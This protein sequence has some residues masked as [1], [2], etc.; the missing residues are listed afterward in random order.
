MVACESLWLD[1]NQ[2]TVLPAAVF[3]GL[4]NLRGLYLNNNELT[5]L[6]AEAF[7]CLTNLEELS[8]FNNQLTALPGG[9]FNCLTDLGILHQAEK[10]PI[11]DLRDSRSLPSAGKEGCRGEEADV[12]ASLDKP[13]QFRGSRVGCTARQETLVRGIVTL[14]LARPV[15]QEST[16]WRVLKP[17]PTATLGSTS[18]QGRPSAPGATQG[19][20][21]QLRASALRETTAQPGSS[22]HLLCDNCEAGKYSPT[23]STVCA[24]S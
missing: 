16:Q 21:R 1:Y 2:L 6:P 22:R 4:T 7:N 20:S 14:R 17:A 19:S 8:L 12:G 18:L 3:N 10:Q 23:S 5:D 13:T 11:V 15:Q 9:V 24:D